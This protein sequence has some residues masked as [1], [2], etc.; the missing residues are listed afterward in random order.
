MNELIN[1]YK[2][3]VDRTLLRQNLKLTPQERFEKFH[4]V[5]R[6]LVALREAGE[7]VRKHNAAVELNESTDAINSETE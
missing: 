2:H 7:R 4:G 6:S 1:A 3:D 5:M